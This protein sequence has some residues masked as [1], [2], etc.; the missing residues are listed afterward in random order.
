[1]PDARLPAIAA[2]SASGRSAWRR[3]CWGAVPPSDSV[4][5]VRHRTR[6][7]L[8]PETGEDVGGPLDR[9]QRAPAVD[10]RDRVE[11]E[12]QRR[13]DTEV[14]TAAPQRPEQVFLDIRIGAVFP[15]LLAEIPFDD[16]EIAAVR[17]D[18][19]A[20]MQDLIATAQRDGDLRPDVTHGDIGMML[21]RLS[22]PLPG[23]LP[24]EL[25]EDL[26]HRQLDLIID[27]LRA[28][29]ARPGDLGGPALTFGDL[30]SLG[31]DGPGERPS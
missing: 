13:H 18:G 10:R 4:S 25:G 29:A 2:I 16:E 14:A 15:V 7:R 22:R 24:R 28:S 31:G 30:G 20:V 6:V 23:P 1:M 5:A 19:I 21:V 12:L 26:A 11:P 8:V 27:G 3:K 9:A 17:A